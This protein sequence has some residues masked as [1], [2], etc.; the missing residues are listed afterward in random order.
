MA[1]A[2]F[3]DSLGNDATSRGGFDQ[4]FMQLQSSD[5][6][7]MVMVSAQFIGNNYFAWSRAVRRALTA[8]MKLDFIDGTASRPPTNTD[9]FR[10]WNRI[11]SIVTTCMLNCMSK[12]LVESFMYVAS[13]RE[14]WLELEA[15]FGESNSPMIY[16]LQKEIG[17]V[18]QGN[19]SI[20]EYYTKLKHLWDELLCLAP[21]PKCVCA[22]C[23]CDVNKAMA[24]VTASNQLIQF[25]VGLSSVYEQAR[26]QILLLDPLPSVTKAFSMLIRIE[27]QM[28]VSICSMEPRSLWGEEEVSVL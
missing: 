26:N 2:E 4:E 5:H 20:T 8:K 11:D 10:R 18:T 19:M 21:A 1:T 6:S 16:Q 23:T 12:E 22:G 24:E 15:Q 28:Q 3:T 17:Q 25:L 14:L 13:S 9:E 7:G 27:K